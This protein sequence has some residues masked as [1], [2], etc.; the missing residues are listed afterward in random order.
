MIDNDKENKDTS[1]TYS[2]VVPPYK[3]IGIEKVKE[4]QEIDSWWYKHFFKHIFLNRK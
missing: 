1:I 2:F 3:H 4:W